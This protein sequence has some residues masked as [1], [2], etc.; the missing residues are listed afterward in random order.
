MRNTPILATLLALPLLATMAPVHGQERTVQSNLN[1]EASWTALKNMIQAADMKAEMAQILA[2]ASKDCGISG[3][4]YGP[5]TPTSDPTTGC[6]PVVDE[7]LTVVVDNIL[8]CSKNRQFY[9]GTKCISISA[10]QSKPPVDYNPPNS[11]YGDS[12]GG[13]GDAGASDGGASR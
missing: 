6:K 1:T 5:G 11:G 2:N 9:N 3:M 8:E 12:I 10:S 4:L 7:A 13:H